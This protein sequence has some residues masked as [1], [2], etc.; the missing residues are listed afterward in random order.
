MTSLKRTILAVESA[1]AQSYGFTVRTSVIDCLVDATVAQRLRGNGRGA[2]LIYQEPES[3]EI[4]LGV[5]FDP[6]IT[7]RLQLSD[8]LQSLHG[9]NLD[10]FCVLIEEI[11]H[12]HLV[13]NRAS[14]G[15]GVSRL[16]LE[17][18]GEI[19]KVLL[20]G[21][22]LLE[23]TGFSH[24]PQLAHLIFDQSVCFSSQTELYDEAVHY[25]ARH[26]YQLIAELKALAP[27]EQWSIACDAFRGTYELQWSEKLS[28]LQRRRS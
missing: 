17:W 14:K 26:W 1:L 20:A 5:Y 28:L 24:L 21:G 27:K 18:Q 4:E 23:Q 8:P 10:S 15:R 7:S 22:V 11:S 19:D 6:S 25:A 3:N 9:E 16:E 12:F 13:A 2:V